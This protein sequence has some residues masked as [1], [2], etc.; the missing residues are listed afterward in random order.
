M[1]NKSMTEEFTRCAGIPVYL[2]LIR[3]KHDM[4]RAGFE[5]YSCEPSKGAYMH[6][7]SWVG[8]GIYINVDINDPEYMR[9]LLH[10]ISHATM[11]RVGRDLS[12]NNEEMVAES[13]CLLL[14][15]YFGLDTPELKKKCRDYVTSYKVVAWLTEPCDVDKYAFEAF[16]YI[17]TH[18]LPESAKFQDREAV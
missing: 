6:K 15:E 8:E 17:I 12:V 5:Q 3:Y 16:S 7:N 4:V 13:S 10:E 2:D 11:R 9:I 14:I 18:W 1:D